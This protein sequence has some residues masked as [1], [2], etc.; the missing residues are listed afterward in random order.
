MRRTCPWI[1]RSAVRSYRFASHPRSAGALNTHARARLRCGSSPH[2]TGPWFPLPTDDHPLP[3]WPPTLP[4][5]ATTAAT[6]AAAAAP[7]LSSF[8]AAL[9]PRSA[10]GRDPHHVQPK[11]HRRALPRAGHVQH[12]VDAA[13][14]RQAGALVH[15]AAQ[16]VEHGQ[17][18][19]AHLPAQPPLAASNP[20]GCH[21]WGGGAL[22]HASRTSHAL[23]LFP[24]NLLARCAPPHLASR[25]TSFSVAAL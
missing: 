23:S 8:V 7:P 4:P 10:R 21:V 11:V 24:R 6:T 3:H 17:G 9:R 5:A 13:D 16:R 2:C 18:T 20:G 14:L 22:P 15:H 12:A 1:S 25:Y 19:L